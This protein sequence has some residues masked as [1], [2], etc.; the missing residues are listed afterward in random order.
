[1]R[2]LI[3]GKPQYQDKIYVDVT[4]Y[5][6]IVTWYRITMVTSITVTSL[7][8]DILQRFGVVRGMTVTNHVNCELV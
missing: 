4:C 1:M 5:I 8:L 3:R 7:R 2:I 6:L